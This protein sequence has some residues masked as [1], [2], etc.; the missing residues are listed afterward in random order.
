[1][2]C[3]PNENCLITKE[4]RINQDGSLSRVYQQ[5]CER[6]QLCIAVHE[7]N[8]MP[9]N[10]PEAQTIIKRTPLPILRSILS[11]RR[12]HNLIQIAANCCDA[13]FCNNLAFA[14]TTGTMTTSKE[15]TIIPIQTTAPAM[16]IQGAVIG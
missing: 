1:M 5:R 12:S 4:M 8:R 3:Q 16:P 14:L 15:T 11:H 2:Y 10:T 7:H 9:T 6:R 13:D